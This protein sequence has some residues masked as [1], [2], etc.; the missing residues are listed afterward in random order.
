MSKDTPDPLYDVK[1]A[2]Y[3]GNYQQCIAEA[4]SLKAADA[5]TA[6]RR[7]VYLYRAYLAQRNYAV[8]L[9]EVTRSSAAEVQAVRQLAQYLHSPSKRNSVL[10]DIEGQLKAGVDTTS[11]TMFIVAAAIYAH[12]KDYGTAL[13]TLH[14]TQSLECSALTVQY[15]LAIDCVSAAV[16]EVKR[17]MDEDEYFVLT[18][19][20]QAWVH[21]SVGGAKIQDAFYIFQEAIDRHGTTAY[22]LSNQAACKIHEGQYEDATGLLQDALE[23]DSNSPEVLVNLIVVS[24]KMGKPVEVTRR[25]IS[26]M[27]DT[28][29][30]H[31]YTVE[32]LEKDDAFDRL[33]NNFSA[34]VS[35]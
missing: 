6:V 17:M 20:A 16:A 14:Q 9:D 7:D 28:H 3:V 34:K 32:Y 10:E 11:D 24:S 19:F 23:K 5:P 8:V 27:K 4:Q 22:L 13:K 35:T 30:D 33:A 18:Q 26:Q 1:T 12:R 31:Y 15:L 21:M 2:F 29:P 25:Y